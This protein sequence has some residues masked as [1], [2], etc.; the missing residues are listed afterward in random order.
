MALKKLGWA[1]ECKRAASVRL[2][3]AWAPSGQSAKL[4]LQQLQHL[5][6]ELLAAQLPAP[7]PRLGRFL[8]EGLQRTLSI[9]RLE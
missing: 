3:A 8:V 9:C 6:F 4:T 5:L 2:V 1:C 7:R